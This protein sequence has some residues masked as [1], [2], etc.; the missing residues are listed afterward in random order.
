MINLEINLLSSSLMIIKLNEENKSFIEARVKEL[1]QQAK[2]SLL[3]RFMLAKLYIIVP[4]LGKTETAILILTDLCARKFIPAFTFLANCYQQGIGIK[5]DNAKI[6]ANDLKIKENNSQNQVEKSEVQGDQANEKLKVQKAIEIYIKGIEL[7][8]Q[9]CSRELINYALYNKTEFVSIEHKKY[10]LDYL[11]RLS[12]TSPEHHYYLGLTWLFGKISEIDYKKSLEHF[13]QASLSKDPDVQLL[14]LN[15][16]GCLYGDKEKDYINAC[17]AFDKAFQIDRKNAQTLFN[18]ALYVCKVSG[19]AAEP[20]LKKARIYLEQFATVNKT[21]ELQGNAFCFLGMIHWKNDN[22][23]EAAK[24][25][26]KSAQNN[27]EDGMCQLA[28]CYFSEDIQINKIFINDQQHSVEMLQKLIKSQNEKIA[29]KAM[30]IMARGYELGKIKTGRGIE[31]DSIAAIQYYIK[32]ADKGSQDSIEILYKPVNFT[33]FTK[34][35]VLKYYVEWLQRRTAIQDKRASIRL[36]MSYFLSDTIGDKSYIELAEKLIDDAI[37]GIVEFILHSDLLPEQ[38]ASLI[39]NFSKSLNCGNKIIENKMLQ[40]F[41]ELAKHFQTINVGQNKTQ[42]EA[43]DSRMTSTS[44]GA[45]QVYLTLAKINHGETLKT[46]DALCYLGE[47]YEFGHGLVQDYTKAEILYREANN[48]EARKHLEGLLQKLRELLPTSDAKPI[49][50]KSKTVR[51]LNVSKMPFEQLHRLVFNSKVVN[52]DA[53]L[54]L[55]QFK[56]AQCYMRTN[57]TFTDRKM[58]LVLLEQLVAKKY[59]KAYATL[60][61]LYEWEKKQKEAKFIYEKGILEMDCLKCKVNYSRIILFEKSALPLAEEVKKAIALLHENAD[62]SLHA[63][64][65]LGQCYRL[66]RALAYNHEKALNCYKSAF[67]SNEKPLKAKAAFGMA[68]IYHFVK[69]DLKSAREFYE[70]SAKLG[71]SEANQYSQQIVKLNDNQGAALNALGV[72]ELAKGL[73]NDV[74]GINGINGVHE[75]KEPN[76]TT[77]FGKA[78]QYFID[79]VQQKSAMALYNLAFCHLLGWGVKEDRNQAMELLNQAAKS[80]IIRA[81]W[82]QAW[83]LLNGFGIKQDINKALEIFSQL[84]YGKPKF[85]MPMIA[86]LYGVDDIWEYSPINSNTNSKGILDPNLAEICKKRSDLAFAIALPLL[87]GFSCR[88]N[89]PLAVTLLQ[90]SGDQILQFLLHPELSIFH[91][92][93]FFNAFVPLLNCGNQQVEAFVAYALAVYFLRGVGT[94]VDLK[95]ASILFKKANIGNIVKIQNIC[96]P[97]SCGFLG[98]SFLSGVNGFDFD[99]VRGIEFLQ[100]TIRLKR[101]MSSSMK[102]SKKE[103][104]EQFDYLDYIEVVKDNTHALYNLGTLYC[105]DQHGL[106]KNMEKA[107]HIFKLG[108]SLGCHY[109]AFELGQYYEFGTLDNDKNIPHQNNTLQITP[110]LLQ[111]RE[112]YQ[113]AADKQY[114]VAQIKLAD[115]YHS[116]K[117][118]EFILKN[119]K[120]LPLNMDKNSESYFPKAIELLESASKQG[121]TFAMNNLACCYQDGVGV[122]QNMTKAFELFLQASPSNPLAKRNL[123]DCYAEGIGVIKNIEIAEALYRELGKSISKQ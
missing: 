47:C 81:R 107:I 122:T 65:Y 113:F 112:Y 118:K 38:Q 49:T 51:K 109:A 52:S 4:E 66:G 96:D 74:K 42:K 101:T 8:C 27:N 77:H 6:K 45:K 21:E 36:V 70:V 80:N 111:A 93:F 2:T 119:S 104:K 117:W 11:Q 114:D 108:Y 64:F 78:A 14:S 1:S 123:A 22:F 30:G 13:K 19:T 105:S 63:Q 59:I 69:I 91:Q 75:V 88:K 99:A 40:I 9:D 32:S 121:N 43:A 71:Y 110:N 97:E 15:N 55:A 102:D 25:Y 95:K 98:K 82:T 72:Y 76:E 106:K 23:E 16:L 28:I 31:E 73:S 60:G 115:L 37:P 24:C 20:W 44:A 17:K 100:Q 46:P 41:L 33:N 53:Q 29:A 89:L 39:D 84:T 34:S 56:L 68:Q 62:K 87:I 92:K 48:D 103:N 7:N 12:L 35:Y 10:L 94:A 79:A 61:K 58:A 54:S 26:M 50:T 18:L 120:D 67:T 116:E 90:Q 5:I 83:F 57:G 86:F 3:Q 85:A